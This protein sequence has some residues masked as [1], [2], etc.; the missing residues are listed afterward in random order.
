[1]EW[2][3]LFCSLS[4]PCSCIT[5]EFDTH[6]NEMQPTH[7]QFYSGFIPMFHKTQR[8]Y[9][10]N[11]S[12]SNVLSTFDQ[13]TGRIKSSDSS[14]EFLFRPLQFFAFCR[15]ESVTVSLLLEQ[16]KAA[17][18]AFP[19]SQS[20]LAPGRKQNFPLST[21]PLKNSSM[22]RVRMKLLG[23]MSILCVMAG[24]KGG[25]FPGSA[26]MYSLVLS[27]LPEHLLLGHC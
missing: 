2:G 9:F 3:Y 22:I 25:A 4:C 17:S 13:G 7:T 11:S 27:P 21:W 8:L 6:F 12:I 5:Q 10:A 18:P 14:F 1:M 26:N 24:W 20:D 19:I 15:T 16:I 23:R